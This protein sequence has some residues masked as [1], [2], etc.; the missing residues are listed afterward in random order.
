MIE[1]TQYR[2]AFW[3]SEGEWSGG[4]KAGRLDWAG[5]VLLMVVR[6]P[7][8]MLGLLSLAATLFV[9]GEPEPWARTLDH[10]RVVFVI[11]ADLVALALL[12]WLVR[13]E[14]GRLRDLIG[15]DRQRLSRDLLIG[16]GLFVL[17]AVVMQ[18]ASVLG[19]LAAYGPNG[20]D[21]YAAWASFGRLS[22]PIWVLLWTTLVFPVTTAFV[23]EMVFRGYATPRVMALTGRAWLAVLIPATFFGLVHLT[24]PLGSWQEA[25]ARFVCMFAVGVVLELL[26][27]RFKRLVPLIV[28]HWA[29]LFA[30]LGLLPLLLTLSDR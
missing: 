1:R 25:L 26:Y 19:A 4:Q 27:L 16:L 28:G 18:A 22:P 7:L 9:V 21:P 30:F 8:I 12:A 29:L 13:R 5:P 14:G 15:F 3:A 24:L 6:W 10:F 2:T 23:E 11:C 17:F 20:L